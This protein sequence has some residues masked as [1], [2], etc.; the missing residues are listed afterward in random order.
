MS[1]TQTAHL[2]L[3]TV[4]EGG[5][6]VAGS[7]FPEHARV[8]A[9]AWGRLPSDSRRVAMREFLSTVGAVLVGFVAGCSGVDSGGSPLEARV[10]VQAVL[11]VSPDLPQQLVRT[12]PNGVDTKV[13]L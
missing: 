12:L 11:A 1:A 8:R 7:Q 13:S 3:R 9:N 6:L 10:G 2:A 5:A 4:G